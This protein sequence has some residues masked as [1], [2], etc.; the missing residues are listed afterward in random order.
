M[1]SIVGNAI[2]IY[3]IVCILSIANFVCDANRFLCKSYDG[4]TKTLE[5]YGER[6]KGIVPFDRCTENE[7]EPI[8]AG[9][10]RF[11]KAGGCD[12]DL[13]ASAI[14]KLKYLRTLDLS[15]SY[16]YETLDWLHLKL[17]WLKKL[18]ASHIELDFLP[19]NFFQ[20]TP[21]LTEIDMSHNKLSRIDAMAFSGANKLT[22]IS[23]G[24]NR[25]WIVRYGAIDH[26]NDLEYLD[27]KRNRIASLGFFS[28][29]EKLKALHVEENPI[30]EFYCMHNTTTLSL[31]MSWKNIRSIYG[32]MK[33]QV[34]LMSNYEAILPV[35]MGQQQRQQQ[36]QQYA[37]YCNPSSFENLQQFIA[38]GST[39]EN[40]TE[41]LWCLGS[42]VTNID[43][44]GNSLASWDAFMLHRFPHL[45]MLDLSDTMLSYF[46]LNVIKNYG[47][48]QKL[49]ISY[50]KLDRIANVEFLQH[51]VNLHVLIAAG[52]GLENAQEILRLLSSSVETLDLSDCFIGELDAM[53]FVRMTSLKTL[54]LRHTMLSL[55]HGSNPFEM[56]G[57]LTHLDI[58]QNYFKTLNLAMILA[59]LTNLNTLNVA[60]CNI[61]SLPRAASQYA[62]G[63]TIQMLNISG[64]NIGPLD[65]HSFE[66]FPNLE[67]LNLS[68]TTLSM[69]PAPN[70]NPFD[71]L[72]KLRILD[73]AYNNLE[74]MNF[75]IWTNLKQLLELNV[76]HCHLKNAFDLTKHMGK[77]LIRLDL[78]GN[79]LLPLNEQTFQPLS[80]LLYLDLSRSNLTRFNW[81]ILQHQNHLIELRLSNNAHLH[82][83]EIQYKLPYLSILD[84]HENDLTSIDRVLQKQ[85]TTLQSLDISR[86]RFTCIYLKDLV[87]TWTHIRFTKDSWIQKY[88]GNCQ[89]HLV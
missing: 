8:P 39:F 53:T 45:Q 67:Y 3:T 60:Y 40:I 82:E 86:N 74:K 44:S 50:N 47:E 72:E 84:L 55:S 62:M 89:T 4:S 88:K 16:G 52:T 85:A 87:R 35:S 9:Q 41:M 71:G 30:T 63:R 58:S 77:S 19:T 65:T 38:G 51:F 17:E 66:S 22:R 10:V 46:D 43:L 61:Q 1:C 56:L 32:C 33:L 59:P 20:H 2:A 27:L 78:S 7:I 5:M 21:R 18:N 69:A 76:A 11:L 70:G 25:I 37:I 15:Y 12:C 73:I 23:L 48:L 26:L 14:E 80:N 68:N 49:D 36:Q 34:V 83:I 42:Q 81:N 24:S 57:N 28:K 54:K 75:S 79:S 13:V 64:N 29:N 31:F 6:F